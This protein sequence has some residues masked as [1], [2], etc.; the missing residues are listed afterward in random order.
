VK[1]QISIG[2]ILVVVVLS[3]VAISYVNFARGGSSEKPETAHHNAVITVPS[4]KPSDINILNTP[5]ETSHFM[6]GV[7]F[8][9]LDTNLGSQSEQRL[10][11]NSVGYVNTF[12][13]GWGT[14]NPEP[15]PGQ[16][17]WS[18]LDQQVN[19]MRN[20]KHMSGGRT[21]LMLSLCCAPDWMKSDSDINTAPNPQ[22]YADFA[23]LARR[24]ALRYPDV[25]YFQVWNELKGFDNPSDYMQLYNDVYD[26]VKAVRPDA[27]VGGPYVA[28]VPDDIPDTVT[29]LWL[30]SKHGG[31]FV[32]VDGGFDSQSAAGDF[33]GAQFYL[34]YA[35]WL[36]QQGKG[37]A[38]LPFGWAEWYPGTTQAWGDAQHFNATM[39]NA[40]IDTLESGASYALMWGI[41]GGVTG[42]YMEGDGQQLTLIDNGQP[43]VWDQ[44]LKDFTDYFGP[45]T[46]ILAVKETQHKAVTVLASASKTILVNQLANKQ[47]VTIN[48]TQVSLNPYQVL[49]MNTPVLAT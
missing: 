5:V 3:G 4:K 11:A 33:S 30:G 45:G 6:P 20:I 46:Q 23:D 28:I 34:N 29:A 39:T 26:A 19:I 36:R 40:L 15:S 43:T 14:D 32:V 2:I 7:T 31:D 38:T 37:G 16:Y 24:V 12:I 9:Q 44:M 21:Q 10:L 41:E 35:R 8:I 17:D 48:G 25:K 22:N 13:Y 18:S 1:K 27:L 42:A 49:V 47:T